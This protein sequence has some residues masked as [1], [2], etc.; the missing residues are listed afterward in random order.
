MSY[1]WELFTIKSNQD[2]FLMNAFIYESKRRKE[3]KSLQW[4][5]YS[6]TQ[7]Q[8]GGRVREAAKSIM[9][10]CFIII[11]VF[12]SSIDFESRILILRLCFRENLHLA[13]WSWGEFE[14]EDWAGLMKFTLRQL[15]FVYRFKSLRLIRD[16]NLHLHP[17]PKTSSQSRPFQG[18]QIHFK[19]KTFSIWLIKCINWIK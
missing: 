7:D 9:T 1:L 18:S 10:E 19:I 15:V 8:A 14:V 2:T 3:A 16:F 11:D 5:I 17:T 12:I 6:S 4:I 13:D